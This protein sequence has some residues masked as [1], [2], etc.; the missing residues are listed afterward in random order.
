MNNVSHI[1]GFYFD[2]VHSATKMMAFLF[3]KSVRSLSVVT[4]TPVK[5]DSMEIQS[6]Y[7]LN[8]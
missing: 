8:S 2:Q 5:S 7:Y 6:C 3:K 1:S 4:V